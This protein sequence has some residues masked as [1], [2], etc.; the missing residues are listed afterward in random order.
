MHDGRTYEAVR[1]TA[2]GESPATAPD[3]W[4]AYDP[5]RSASTPPPSSMTAVPR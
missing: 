1:A 2:K 4:Q 3:A 5:Q